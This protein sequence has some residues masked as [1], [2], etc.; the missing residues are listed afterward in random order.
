LLG[1]RGEG[2]EVRSQQ[3]LE[4]GSLLKARRNLE[5]IVGALVVLVIAGILGFHFIEHWSYFDGFYMVLTTIT[6]IGYGELHPLSHTGRIFNVFVIVAGVSLLFLLIGTVTQ[7]LLEFE[8]RSFFG[9]RRMERDIRR[10]SGHYIIC[11]AGRVGRSVARELV[12]KDV[13][14]VLVEPDSEKARRYS[15][16]GWL[17][18]VGDST[19]SAVLREARIDE[20]SGLVAAASTD[21]INTYIVL[22]ARS[23]NPKIKIVARASEEDAEK[24][25]LT[26]GADSVVLPYRFAGHRIAQS[27]LQPHVLDFIDSA[28]VRL[29]MDLEISEIPVSP[30]SR[31][32]GQTLADS[33]MRNDF[34]VIV[35]AIKRGSEMLM[36][37]S[38]DDVV[39]ANDFLIAMGEPGALRKL[40]EAATNA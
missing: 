9:R 13:P 29:G 35:L 8:L 26:A 6:T 40:E 10:L 18:V 27:F 23:L 17:T 5:I 32:V 11:G 20:A 21:A 33:H 31:Y 14:F 25:L 39:A 16:E 12:H 2:W 4:S 38:P 7:I 34:G 3:K 37:P 19:Q 28:T 30:R 24:H 1:T 36:N 22:T 15:E